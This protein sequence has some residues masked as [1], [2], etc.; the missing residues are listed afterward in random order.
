M[1]AE[2]WETNRMLKPS[3]LLQK[4]FERKKIKEIYQEVDENFSKYKE[5]PGI[6]YI[7]SDAFRGFVTNDLP[8]FWSTTL[9]KSFKNR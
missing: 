9:S 5:M 4:D 8:S 1:F 2:F 3:S 6:T 7:Y